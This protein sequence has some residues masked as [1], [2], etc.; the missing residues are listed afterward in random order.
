M[1]VKR[2]VAAAGAGLT[3][4]M[5]AAVPAGAATT[6][7]GEPRWQALLDRIVASGAV[8]AVA[9][10]RDGTRTWRGT[11]GKARLGGARPA[12]VDGRFRIGSVTKSFTAAVVLQLA[13]EGKLSLSDSLERWLPG[14]VAGGSRITVRHLL[15]HTSGIPEYSTTMFDRWGIPK[16]R[17]R[18]WSARELVKMADDLP[19]EFA[20]GARYGYSNTNFIVLGML[21]EKVTGSSYAA[22]VRQR[23]LRPLGL[24]GTF[25]PEASPEVPGP[26][27]HAYVPVTRAGQTVPVDVTRFNPTMAGSAGEIIST[28]AD[29][30]RFFRALF[31]GRL[32]RPAQQK[33]MT[34]PG[35]IKEY[36]LGLEAGPLPCGT[37]WGHG[38]GTHGYSTVAF[39]SADGSRQLALSMTPYS[40]DPEKAA[41]TMLVTALCS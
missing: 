24:H 35:T 23:I 36:G 34:D 29:L 1:N 38:G 13:G 8:S 27:A 16:E 33:Q 9:E 10:V 21:I 32:L 19:R 7:S 11:S 28:T 40:G 3:M 26:H 5:A 18:T 4:T 6:G 17:L 15:Q 39:S 37:A 30:N 20:P 31:Q 41:M 12:P 25:V 2:T 22:E 14:L